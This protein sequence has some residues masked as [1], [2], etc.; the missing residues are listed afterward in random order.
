[1]HNYL[2]KAV[3]RLQAQLK[4][5]NDEAASW[6]TE[7]EEKLNNIISSQTSDNSSQLKELN[8]QLE[9]FAQKKSTI[10]KYYAAYFEDASPGVQKS[11]ACQPV[12]VNMGLYKNQLMNPNHVQAA[13]N[14]ATST[15]WSLRWG[16]P[17]K[18][19]PR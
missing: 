1:M 14:R 12:P 19:P 11:T 15:R 17:A 16:K 13:Y 7:N 3:S 2:D 9:D 4:A 18:P 6:K 8:Q 5:I 10:R